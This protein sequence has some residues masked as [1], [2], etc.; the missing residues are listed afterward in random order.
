M[1]CRA[2]KGKIWRFPAKVFTQLSLEQRGAGR[3]EK[4]GLLQETRLG[5]TL[6]AICCSGQ[7]SFKCFSVSTSKHQQDISSERLSRGIEARLLTRWRGS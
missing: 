7:T 5:N 1:S 2:R 4:G 3:S 6:F